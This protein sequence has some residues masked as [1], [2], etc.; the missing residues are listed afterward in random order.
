MSDNPDN[1]N[2]LPVEPTFDQLRD[3]FE[4]AYS[5][6]KAAATTGIDSPFLKI[7][8]RQLAHLALPIERYE[9]DCH[10]ASVA[11]FQIK[12]LEVRDA[13][14]DVESKSAMQLQLQQYR[15]SVG[16]I[17]ELMLLEIDQILDTPITAE[18]LAE[19]EMDEF[20]LDQAKLD[21]DS[22]N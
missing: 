7:H 10:A 8:L 6:W 21:V 1:E 18:M 3:E 4:S 12:F 14:A 20:E 17:P 15:E 9:E 16:E 2:A 13:L 11:S 19:F 22:E 5:V